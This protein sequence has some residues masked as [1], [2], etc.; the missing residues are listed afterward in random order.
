MI[1]RTLPPGTR[2]VKQERDAGDIL[3]EAA[4]TFNERKAAYKDNFIRLGNSLAAMF[5][6][7]IILKWPEDFVRFHLFVLQ[8]TKVSRYATNFETGG[9]QDS[10]HDAIVYAA[11]LE[12]YDE[13]LR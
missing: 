9:H 1:D 3:Q 12:A 13:G 11:L 5:P 10:I 6:N 2:G 7:G 4:T 8:Q